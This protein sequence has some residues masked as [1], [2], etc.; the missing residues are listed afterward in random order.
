MGKIVSPKDFE[1]DKGP[2]EYVAPHKDADGIASAVLFAICRGVERLIWL[3]EFGDTDKRIQVYLDQ[4]PKD[5]EFS[6]LV[7]DHHKIHIDRGEDNFNYTVVYDEVPTTMIVYNLIQP[8]LMLN[9]GELYKK[10]G[11]KLA[12]GLMGDGQPH[13]IPEFI[14]KDFPALHA[15][16]MSIWEDWSAGGNWKTF[17][18]PIHGMLASGINALARQGSEQTAYEILRDAKTP[19]EMVN[20]SSIYRAKE[21]QKKEIKRV[22]K[23]NKPIDFPNVILWKFHSEFAIA[24]YLATRLNA[25]S[26]KTVLS[27]NTNFGKLSCR[28]NYTEMVARELN[29]NLET[30]G[31]ELAG[32]VG[33]RGGQIGEVTLEEV[34]EELAKI[35]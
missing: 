9:G 1:L 17:M 31:F 30:K 3:L 16:H 8:D 19:I 6:G 13:L 2:Y 27:W 25:V 28:G 11:W 26:N 32:H 23:E 5:P 24:S 29:S 18:Y 20:H 7:I 33:Y 14:W 4:A 15:K 34:Y 12:V 21:V 10:H 22:M 35:R